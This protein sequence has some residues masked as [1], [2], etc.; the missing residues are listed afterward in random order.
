MPPET[1]GR[2]GVSVMSA[3][4]R[5][6]GFTLIELLV[7]V[8]IIALLISVLLPSLKQAREQARL[9]KCLANL[10]SLGKAALAYINNENERFCYG[11]VRYSAAG[12]LVRAQPA[13]NYFGGNRGEGESPHFEFYKP[14]GSLAFP[15]RQRPLNRYVLPTRLGAD[16]DL[17]VYECPS[18]KGVR[19]HPRPLSEPS[20]K[21]A[22][23]VTGT[24]YQANTSWESYVRL[25]ELGNPGSTNPARNQRLEHLMD[26]MIKIL[27]RRGAS[28][29][30]L[31]YEDP[32]DIGLAGVFWGWPPDVKMD[33][34]HTKP[35][36]HSLLF[37]DGHADNVLVE[38]RK[39]LDHRV[40]GGFFLEC[41]PS[42]LPDPACSHGSADW[43]ARHDFEQ[44]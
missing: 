26:R 41:A 37:L 42:S 3:R 10:S 43:I 34:W 35:N 23:Q 29:A 28:R 25:V 30:I 32:A 5:S 39:N 19:N 40:A 11:Y 24:S 27:N 31:L 22:Y 17:K 14:G 44:D 6:S 36:R 13:T 8:A 16:S 2:K 18:D 7:V 20:K 9:T 12:R 33:S 15:A 4:R 21:T 1:Q 38:H